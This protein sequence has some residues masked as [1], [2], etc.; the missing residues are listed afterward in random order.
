M[1]EEGTN[2]EN[3]AVY[4]AGDG[5]DFVSCPTEKSGF[6]EAEAERFAHELVRRAM[7]LQNTARM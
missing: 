7:S 4:E 2:I 3:V 1:V 5:G 6:D